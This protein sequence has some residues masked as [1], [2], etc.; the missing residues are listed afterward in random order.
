MATIEDSHLHSSQNDG[1]SQFGLLYEQFNGLSASPLTA[2]SS[3]S[4]ESVSSNGSFNNGKHPEYVFNS[5]MASSSAGH[6]N[7]TATPHHFCNSPAQPS[8]MNMDYFDT[9]NS[10]EWWSSEEGFYLEK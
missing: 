2:L 4:S 10:I 7:T 1:Y 6:N 8:M 9:L 5:D 3:T